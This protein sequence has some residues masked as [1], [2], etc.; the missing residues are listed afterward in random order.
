MAGA[1]AA[2]PHRNQIRQVLGEHQAG[3]PVARVAG[4]VV[5]HWQPA[6]VAVAGGDLVAFTYWLQPCTQ[7]RVGQADGALVQLLFIVTAHV[8]R[9]GSSV[10]LVL[11]A[12]D[13]T[14]LFDILTGLGR[15]QV[16]TDG[17]AGQAVQLLLEHILGFDHQGQ[18]HHRAFG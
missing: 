3:V 14:S 8:E 16:F 13:C 17:F 18:A 15:G 11:A 6:Q 9:Q 7:Q 5:R 10:Q 2:A 4:R 12:N 1:R